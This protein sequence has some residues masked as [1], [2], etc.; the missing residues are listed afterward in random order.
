[1]LYVIDIRAPQFNLEAEEEAGQLLLA[2]AGGL[3][4]CREAPAGARAWALE[5]RSAQAHAACDDDDDSAPQWISALDTAAE[6][7]AS[8]EGPSSGSKGGAK[9]SKLRPIFAPSTILFDA[10]L[11]DDGAGGDGSFE[12]S[13][14]SPAL[15]AATD[16]RQFAVL[17]DCVTN[18]LLS[19][20]AGGAADPADAAA[21]LLSAVASRGLERRASGGVIARRRSATAVET[22]RS[23]AAAVAE[24]A[25]ALAEAALLED[26]APDAAATTARLRAALAAAH[27]AA[28]DA[29][30]T[31]AFRVT[32]ELGSASWRLRHRGA[33]FLAASLS[34][35]ALA[36]EQA[37][38]C[39]GALA[40][41]LHRLSLRDAT[42]SPAS[43]AGTALLE[44]WDPAGVFGAE[45]M[46]AVT[47]RRGASPRGAPVYE[48]L[49]V[50]LAPAR[51]ALTEALVAQLQAFL[52]PPDPFDKG[53][54]FLWGLQ[55]TS[56]F[57]DS[58]N[59]RQAAR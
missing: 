10:T 9:G 31:P 57:A 12:A 45:P 34:A 23:G 28:R 36:S 19:P 14:R 40:L 41:R 3:V 35:F 58:S 22:T 1:V 46:L 20:A 32:L 27:A 39:S 48:L 56:A 5:L 8:P 16:A 26:D 30:R 25:A 54:A 59:S 42:S 6:G 29:A 17:L 37:E 47:A 51:V 24:V 15:E 43:A 49:D 50:C 4:V 44:A 55:L 13:L 33:T 38:D 52:M 11:R 18:L 2:A 53:C 7:V 21:A